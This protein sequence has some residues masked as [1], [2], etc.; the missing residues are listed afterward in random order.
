VSYSDVL[1]HT[2]SI[3]YLYV[4]KAYPPSYVTYIYFSL[5]CSSRCPLAL[6]DDSPGASSSTP[7]AQLIASR[8]AE[9]EAL[10]ISRLRDAE[11][12]ERSALQ[13]AA[14]ADS[15]RRD[16]V[17]R[18][19]ELATEAVD[20][21]RV[22]EEQ[23]AVE[24]SAVSELILELEAARSHAASLERELFVLRD[25]RELLRARAEARPHTPSRAAEPC[26][27]ESLRADVLALRSLLQPQPPPTAASPL[28]GPRSEG[29]RPQV[30][31]EVEHSVDHT[32]A[33]GQTSPRLWRLS[34]DVAAS[35]QL[36]GY[37]PEVVASRVA[38]A[39]AAAARA[40]VTRSRSCAA[41]RLSRLGARAALES[42]IRELT[43]RASPEAW[44]T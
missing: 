5:A 2:H 21:L 3:T 14:A 4:I 6:M 43:G 7:L 32:S 37:A 15:A 13:R 12:A 1:V 36:S 33:E 27:V 23:L 18:A 41:D 42:A 30:G 39:G 19:S 31:R 44:R 9:R 16:A 17:A 38:A 29:R 8:S 34:R 24:R 35:P 20:A 26:S 28:R 11:Q 22:V 25:E 40:A 10:Y